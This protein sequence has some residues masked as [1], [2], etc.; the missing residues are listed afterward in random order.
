[1]KRFFLPLVPALA[2]FAGDV[3]AQLHAIPLTGPDVVYAMEGYSVLA[4]PGKNWFELKRDGRNVYFGKKIASRTHAFIATAMSGL[5]TEKFEKPEEFRDYVSRMLPLRGDERHTVIENL[6]ELDQAA[7]R[8]C[9]RHHTKAEDRDALYAR[10]KMLLA[11]TIGVSCLH[12]DSPGL[13]ISVS[14]TERG[15]PQEASAALR[16]EGESFVRSLRFTPR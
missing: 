11:E 14:Y 6:V 5:I 1:M 13:S 9:V 3:G 10:G 4:P 12:P 15:Y 16:A 7:G 2:L 8:F